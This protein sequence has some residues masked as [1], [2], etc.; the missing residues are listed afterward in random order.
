MPLQR[1]YRTVDNA[2]ATLSGGTL[3]PFSSNSRKGPH[4]PRAAKR[5][6]QCAALKRPS[7]QKGEALEEGPPKGHAVQL[8]VQFWLTQPAT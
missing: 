8:P 5:S 3:R 2:D 6:G 1:M 4:P 7:E